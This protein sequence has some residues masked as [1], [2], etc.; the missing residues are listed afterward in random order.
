MR[1]LH[2]TSES[3]RSSSPV[4]NRRRLFPRSLAWRPSPWAEALEVYR[5]QGLRLRVRIS[6]WIVSYKVLGGHGR[7]RMFFFFFGGGGVPNQKYTNGPTRTK[8]CKQKNSET[9]ADLNH[10][11]NSAFH[12]GTPE[13]AQ[14]ILR[15]RSGRGRRSAKLP[16]HFAA[17]SI[18]Q[19]FSSTTTTN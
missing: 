15:S 14:V 5:V 13:T 17:F 2:A 18:L 19:F 4:Q 12:L 7:I 3:Y 1:P 9:L 6:D 10:G 8:P 16:K 11:S